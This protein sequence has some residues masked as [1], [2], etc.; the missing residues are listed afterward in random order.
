MRPRLSIISIGV[1]DLRRA[2]A[3]YR[4]GL[5]FPLIDM[6]DTDHDPAQEIAFFRLEDGMQLVVWSFGFMAADTGETVGGAPSITLGQ[7]VSSTE[8][9]DAAM[10]RAG[11]AGARIVR[12]PVYLP[13]GGYSGYF[14]DPDGHLWEVVWIP[15]RY[16]WTD[17]RFQPISPR[18]KAF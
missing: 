3:F 9:V 16:G 18:K 11:A 17:G 15:P 14:A 4:D 7:V 12:E 13:W 2:V 8:E 6:S 5:G 10:A 1:T